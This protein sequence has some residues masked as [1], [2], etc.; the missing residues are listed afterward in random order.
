M[1]GTNLDLAYATLLLGDNTNSTA[2]DT[3]LYFRSI[4]VLNYQLQHD[5]K[6]RTRQSVPF[7][8]LVTPEVASW[9]REQ[10]SQEGATVVPV[11]KI[12]SS[13]TSPGSKRWQDV[14]VKLRLFELVEFDRILFLDADTF[15][16][17]SLDG[18][19]RD[20]AARPR[21]TLH[22]E[23]IKSDE[24]ALPNDYLFATNSEVMN[25][26]HSYPAVPMSYF[27]AGFF[28]LRPSKELY[29]YYKSLFGLP[30]RFDTT[31]PEQ[32][33]LNYAHR[34]QGNMPWGRLRHSWNIQLPSMD[35]VQ[36]GVASLHAKLWTEGNVLQPIPRELQDLW[37]KK[38]IEMDEHYRITHNKQMA[39]HKE[40]S[41][42]APHRHMR[43]STAH[44]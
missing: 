44:P 20:R 12:D 11:K 17:K 24:G 2:P 39:G 21:R 40:T 27:N 37:W 31:Y 23:K 5:R 3:D 42:G 7:L 1:Y 35:D 8:V 6:T 25:V 22:A 29:K 4:R 16:L 19:F 18:V 9:K 34:Q 38:K 26:M 36:K 30:G 10:L 28:V 43:H 14:M 15:L 32:N 33:L 41:Q 13:W